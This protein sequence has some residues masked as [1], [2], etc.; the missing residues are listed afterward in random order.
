MSKRLPC[1]VRSSTT[2]VALRGKTSGSWMLHYMHKERNFLKQNDGNVLKYLTTVLRKMADHRSTY[3]DQKVKL[4]GTIY[5]RL[6]HQVFMKK[7]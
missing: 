2:Q 5:H 7:M 1:H 4:C 6:T 3:G